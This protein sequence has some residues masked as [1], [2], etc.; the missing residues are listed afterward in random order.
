M[1]AMVIK[2]IVR[3]IPYVFSTAAPGSNLGRDI[4]SLLLSLCTG[5]RAAN[6][7][8]AISKGF[9]KCSTAKA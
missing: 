3:N 5:L 9:R 7:S 4:F 8:S 2:L 1:W 6:P